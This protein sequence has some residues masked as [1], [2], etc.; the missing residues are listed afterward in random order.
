MVEQ[1]K[2]W[3]DDS[4]SL[5][6]NCAKHPEIL[7]L[8]KSDLA[9]GVCGICAS[10]SEKV[11]NP[12]NFQKMVNLFR[13]LIRFHFNEDQYNRH[14]GGTSIQSLLLSEEN[15]LVHNATSDDY[16]DAFTIRIEEE[17]GVY[18]DF[19]KGICLYAGSDEDGLRG[20]QF[21]LQETVC[22][23]L[24]DIEQGLTHKNFHLIEP[25]M[26]A[27][28]SRVENDLDYGIDEGSLW[29]RSRTGVSEESYH[30]G[31]GEV[32]H[33]AVPFKDNEIGALPPPSANAGRANRQGVSVLYLASDVDTAL[34]EI[35]PHPGHLISVG[36]FRSTESLRIASFDQP[37]S[38]FASCDQRL[39]DFS[40]VHHIDALLRAPVVPE[41]R[42]R[43]AV[44]QLL[45]D[46]LIRQGFDGIAFGSS[47]GAGR[48][49]CVFDAAKF[50]FDEDQSYVRRVDGLRYSFS[51]VATET[52]SDF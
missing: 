38:N 8:I 23:P 15:P 42:P 47:V 21:S 50:E 34:S 49:I 5:C 52:P 27:L 1:E 20:L 29:F 19:D 4:V 33:I 22:K 12:K 35:R 7:S 17:G 32:T 43:Y 40:I 36:G 24:R 37:I 44:T 16:A 39:N 18:P 45:A 31:A 13:A 11:F 28:L 41:E 46:C 9:E 3:E 51:E 6:A 2:L 14:W 10:A 26:K 30:V 25:A 48:N